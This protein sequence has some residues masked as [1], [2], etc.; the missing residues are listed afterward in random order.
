M[1]VCYNIWM[2]DTNTFDKE[3]AEERHDSI[4]NEAKRIRDAITKDVIDYYYEY[5]TSREEE[6]AKRE[7]M[8]KYL[9]IARDDID[10]FLN[11]KLY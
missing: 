6:S 8:R 7:G 2:S 1:S 11:G 5:P 4:I 10:I 9:K 3:V